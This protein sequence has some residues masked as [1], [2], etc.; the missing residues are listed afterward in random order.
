MA[1][2]LSPHLDTVAFR[3]GVRDGIFNKRA[4]LSPEELTLLV[5]QLSGG[6]AGAP[7]A[8]SEAPL[9]DGEVPAASTDGT[10]SKYYLGDQS[11]E[12]EASPAT[13]HKID[14]TLLAN[15]DQGRSTSLLPN[16]NPSQLN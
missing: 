10:S 7:T 3:Q 9:N 15:I 16:R 5:Q 11:D 2:T 1:T 6:Q 14:P 13:E 12:P 8:P 4:A